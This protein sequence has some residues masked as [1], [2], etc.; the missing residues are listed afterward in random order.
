[1]QVTFNVFVQ[2]LKYA[3]AYAGGGVHWV[4]VHPPP[5]PTWE[6]SSAQ[7]CSKDARKFR[8][9]MLAKENVHVPLRYDKSKTKKLGGKEEN[10]K[11]KRVKVKEIKKEDSRLSVLYS[12]YFSRL[13]TFVVVLN[14]NILAFIFVFIVDR[15][16][17]YISERL[18]K[19]S[20]NGPNVFI[21]VYTLITKAISSDRRYL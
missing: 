5:P 18:F 6:K 10:S 1:M 14:I 19:H 15:I 9:D 12:R 20:G 7:K 17:S 13:F 11:R 3:G 4:H 2:H 8:L 16:V 21:I